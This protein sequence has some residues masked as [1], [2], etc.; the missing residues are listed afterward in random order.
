MIEIDPS[1]KKELYNAL[2]AE[3]LTLRDW[4]LRRAEVYLEERDQLSLFGA[5]GQNLILQLLVVPS[6]PSVC[7]SFCQRH[8]AVCVSRLTDD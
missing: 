8:S 4:F 5:L 2:D 7:L 6:C 3:G 1:T